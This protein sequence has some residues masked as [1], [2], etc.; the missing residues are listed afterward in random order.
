MKYF[1]TVKSLD[2]QSGQGLIAPD[3]GGGDLSFDQSASSWNRI[4]P[5]RLG[6]RLSYDLHYA[7]GQPSAQNVDTI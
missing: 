7:N 3:T 5:P 6:Q 1:G 2:E 4:A